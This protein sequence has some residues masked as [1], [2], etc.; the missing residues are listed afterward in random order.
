MK[1]IVP[2]V[3]FMLI[4]A[5]CWATKKIT[6]EQLKELL[7]AD[8]K[9][10]KSDAD[11]AAQLKD[12]EL[13]EELTKS[14]MDAV[15]PLVP[16]PLTTEQLFIMEV[17]G[18]VQP[19]PAS[20]IPVKTAPDA[21]GQ[22][23]ILD[24]AVGYAKVF[25]QTPTLTATR[26][27]RRFQDSAQQDQPAFGSHTT[28]VLAPTYA[29][30][31]YAASDQGTV[32]FKNGVEENPL[33]NQKTNWGDNGMIAL[34]GQSPDP[35][36]VLQSAQAEGKMKWLRWQT[37]NG[38]ELAVF[39]FTVDR[40][41]SQY[42]VEYCCFP[43]TSQAGEMAMRGVAQGGGPG[44]YMS[45]ATWKPFKATEGYHGAIYIDPETG[46]IYRLVT[47][48]EFKGSDPVKQENERIDYGSETV[49]G[50]KVVVPGFVTIDTVEQPFPN[51]AQGR[52]IMRHTLFTLTYSDYKAAGS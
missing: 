42:A 10:Q 1:R 37:V 7:A 26:T 27:L 30:I 48:V 11:V 45:N 21:T 20:D 38:H 31:R 50:K 13:T 33:A 8:Q 35:V 2:I 51:S 46:V 4:S 32:T 44:N 24:K 41:K 23:A 5:P 49:N 16:G 36:S 15:K 9:A 28:A 6:M 17:R 39:S 14:T 18:A 29:P 34:L 12:L 47:Q 25:L 40:K 19:P 22:K 52:F 43:E 3:V